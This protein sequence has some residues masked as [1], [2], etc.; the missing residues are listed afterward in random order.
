MVKYIEFGPNLTYN[1][2]MN[3]NKV[4]SYSRY[5]RDAAVLLGRHIE[6]GRKQRKLTEVDLADRAGISRT[7]LQKIEK[8]DPKCE[9]G[10]FFEVAT[11]V[12]VKLFD[13]ASTRSFLLSVDQINDKIALLPKSIRKKKKDLD[14]AF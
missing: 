6:L 7:T 5:T 3:Q 10:L 4:R 1:K 12:G 8:G 14:D 2:P 11:L 13:V 9:L